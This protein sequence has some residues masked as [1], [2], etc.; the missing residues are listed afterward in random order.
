MKRLSLTLTVALIAF[1]GALIW[2]VQGEQQPPDPNRRA[3]IR[4]QLQWF[5]QAQFIGFYVALHERY[6]DDENLDVE[7][8][9]GGFNTNPIQRVMSGT[10]DVGLATGDQVLLRRSGGMPLKA[11]GSV[12]NTSLAA[13]MSRTES[14]ITAPEHLIGKKVGVYEGF[15]T[16]NI[17]RSLLHK[18]RIPSSEVQIVG[19]GALQGFI[20]GEMDVFPAYVINEPLTVTRQGIDVTLMHPDK[21]GIEYISDVLF[22][23]ENYW[24]RNRD[25]LARFLRAS[26]RGWA[27]AE[28]RP[29][30][31]LKIMYAVVE[32]LTEQDRLHQEAMLREVLRHVRA[33]PESTF[34]F[35]AKARWERMEESLFA[36]GKLPTTGLI[37]E[38]CDFQLVDESR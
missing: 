31:A 2:Y 30:R 12:F 29:D 4:L 34:F 13:F 28:T 7:L 26:A 8:I 33:G 25:L 32:N 15:D 21:F 23:T 10:A 1:I 19:A 5:D 27:L 3:A 11:I 36:I 38:L 35:M 18:H 17:L 9:S 22:T 14:G 37:E 24:A 16:E 20:Q 6:Y